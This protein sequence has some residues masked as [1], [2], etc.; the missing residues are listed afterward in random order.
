MICPECKE[1]KAHRSRR[2]GLRDGLEGL[3]LRTPY[4]CGACKVRF[5]VNLRAE[6]SLK[7]RTPEEK[8]VIKL[9]RE[10]QALKIRRQLVGYGLSSLI[11]VLLLY[12]LFQQRIYTE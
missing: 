10:L 11:L 3:F 6:S 12:Y 4:R 9:R 2:S 1:N 8:R 5:Y 7:L